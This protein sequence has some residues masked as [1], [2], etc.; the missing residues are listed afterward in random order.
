M[1]T[2]IFHKMRYDLEGHLN[3]Y[4]TTYM[5]KSFKHIRLMTDFDEYFYEC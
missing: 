1:K 2:Q 3:S 4:K 5:P